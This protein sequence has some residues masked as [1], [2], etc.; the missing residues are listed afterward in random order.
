MARRRRKGLG[1]P[2]GMH[3]AG[4]KRA[5]SEIQSRAKSTVL[6]ARR[7]QCVRATMAYAEMQQAI[8]K[9]EAHVASGGNAWKPQ[10]DIT[11]AAYEYN[12]RCVK[13]DSDPYAAGV[14]GR[15]RRRR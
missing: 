7:G 12:D 2:V 4:A 10:T 9:L 14:S 13:S 6:A 15:R 5:A 8:G 3:H 1:S 11:E